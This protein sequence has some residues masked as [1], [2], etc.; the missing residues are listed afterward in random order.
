MGCAISRQVTGCFYIIINSIKWSFWAACSG[1]YYSVHEIRMIER[2]Q[3]RRRRGKITTIIFITPVWPASY[4]PSIII[5]DHPG[6]ST[7][8]YSRTWAGHPLGKW[9]TW[10]K[11]MKEFLNMGGY[12]LYVWGS[13][14]MTALLLLVEPLL[15]HIRRNTTLRRG[16]LLVRSKSAQSLKTPSANI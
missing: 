14:G 4:Y 2:K 5:Y 3:W 16:S 15:V 8:D 12:A 9:I 7:F 13:F 6:K 11:S 10:D 1:I